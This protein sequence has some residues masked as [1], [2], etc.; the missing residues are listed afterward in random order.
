M[1]ILNYLGRF[2]VVFIL[3]AVVFCIAAIYTGWAPMIGIAFAILFSSI[4][5]NS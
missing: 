5:C 1:S 3:A 2:V 4:V